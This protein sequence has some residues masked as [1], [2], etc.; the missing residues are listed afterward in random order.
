VYR[1]IGVATQHGSL[2]LDGEHALSTELIEGHVDFAV[3]ACFE[4][5]QH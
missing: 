5:H 4:R 1:H 3:A 2:H